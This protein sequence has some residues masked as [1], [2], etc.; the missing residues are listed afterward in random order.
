M[1][2]AGVIRRTD[3]PL[4]SSPVI[5]V[6]RKGNAGR[7]QLFMEP[8]WPTDTTYFLEVPEG[9][10]PRF[11]AYQLTHRQL[12]GM[13]R[14]T[15]VPSLQRGDLE[16]TEVC[17]PPLSEQEAIVAAM[18]EE[19]SRIEK[20]NALLDATAKRMESLQSATLEDEIAVLCSSDRSL[21][22]VLVVDLVNGRSVPDGAGY[23][24]L[25]LDAID[26]GFVDLSR[27]KRGSWS[28]EEGRRFRIANGDL[29]IVRGNGSIRLVGR[30]GLVR[31]DAEMAFPDTL[32]RARSNPSIMR[33]SFLRAIWDSRQVRR[34]LVESART[35]AGIYKVNQQ[36][37]RK[38]RI[39]YANVAD[40]D[41]F[42]KRADEIAP[43]LRQANGHLARAS[44]SGRM[45]K[46]AVLTSAFSGRLI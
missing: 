7:V 29:L 41:R 20:A 10:D 46:Q 2:S 14:S 45:I 35:T 44:H 15:A 36:Q 22:E 28:P 19:F 43:G 9:L 42:L 32:I 34:Q 6:G 5:V 11:L 8:I 24:V 3:E 17:L 4:T 16:G 40:Q 12:A 1:A 21:Q 18:E 37:L 31:E 38:I 30:A 33:P 39:P 23:P 27:C 13:D 25:R 26:R